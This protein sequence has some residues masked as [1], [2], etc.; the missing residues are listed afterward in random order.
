MLDAG[1]LRSS[2]AEVLGPIN[3]TNPRR[4]HAAIGAGHMRGKLVLEGFGG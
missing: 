4:A 1:M 2:L 3:A